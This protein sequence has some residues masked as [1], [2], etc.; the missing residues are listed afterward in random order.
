MALAAK[1]C[2]H[3]D[4][5]P[6]TPHGTGWERVDGWVALAL[7]ALAAWPPL[8]HDPEHSLGDKSQSLL[9]SL[10]L[11]HGSPWLLCNALVVTAPLPGSQHCP[12]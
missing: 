2:W 6:C 11:S 7:L 4:R 1:C 8:R 9:Q 12:S 3:R 5:A 10:L